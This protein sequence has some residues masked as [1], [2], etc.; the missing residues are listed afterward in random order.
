MPF[1]L[2][3]CAE[4]WVYLP[5]QRPC[6]VF[7]WEHYCSVVLFRLKWIYYVDV[8]INRW[9]HRD[10][11]SQCGTRQKAPFLP[12][13]MSCILR[14]EFVMFS[15]KQGNT[16]K[17]DFPCASQ[18]R[19]N[20][21]QKKGFLANAASSRWLPGALSLGLKRTDCETSLCRLVVK[22]NKNTC[23]HS[24]RLSRSWCFIQ[25]KDSVFLYES[26]YSPPQY[27]TFFS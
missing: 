23:T 27:C 20:C 17:I 13:D 10:N 11:C 24:S 6:W 14:P 18:L 16:V 26:G 2:L 22:L 7:S 9:T 25:H 19:F 5:S 12:Y 21:C 3:H 8:L 1:V 4:R 15:V